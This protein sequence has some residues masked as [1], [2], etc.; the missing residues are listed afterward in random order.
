MKETL[1]TLIPLIWVTSPIKVH[2]FRLQISICYK[3]SDLSTNTVMKSLYFTFSLFE[4]PK[5]LTLMRELHLSKI[6]KLATS[7]QVGLLHI[8]SVQERC[9][10][11]SCCYGWKITWKNTISLFAVA[12]CNCFWST[13]SAPNVKKEGIWSFQKLAY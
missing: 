4:L 1:F 9:T 3:L 2:A 12:I 8:K 11:I 7:P 10:E 5:Y 6:Q 13:K